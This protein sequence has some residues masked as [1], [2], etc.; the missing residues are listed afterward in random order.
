M[1][2]QGPWWLRQTNAAMEMDDV[3]MYS[4]SYETKGLSMA[5]LVYQ[6]VSID[7]M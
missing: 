1:F 3:N 2:F 5:I 6:R 7:I 4:I